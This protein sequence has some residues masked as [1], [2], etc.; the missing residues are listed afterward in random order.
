LLSSSTTLPAD[1]IACE[2]EALYS[3]RGNARVL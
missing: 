2:E 1:E 3:A